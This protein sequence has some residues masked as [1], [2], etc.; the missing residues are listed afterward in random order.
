MDNDII[1]QILDWSW[2]HEEDTSDDS[3]QKYVIRLFGRTPKN[4]TI[5]VKVNNYTPFFYIEVPNSW[6]D[7]MTSILLAEVKKKHLLEKP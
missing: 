2:Y 6:R 1:F 7:Y 5:Y 3:M 4:E